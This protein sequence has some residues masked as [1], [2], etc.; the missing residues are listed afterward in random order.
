MQIRKTVEG[1]MVPSALVGDVMP[2]DYPDCFAPVYEDNKLGVLHVCIC[3]N[4]ETAKPRLRE[5][6]E[7]F[8]VNVLY[9]DEEGKIRPIVELLSHKDL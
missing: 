5:V 9:K 7:L 4:C 6:A 3:D 1:E 8:K 2:I